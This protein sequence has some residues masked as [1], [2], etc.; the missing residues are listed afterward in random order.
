MCNDVCEFN[1][2]S[3]S[4]PIQIRVLSLGRTYSRRQSSSS[5]SSKARARLELVAVSFVLSVFRMFHTRTENH[6]SPPRVKLLIPPRSRKITENPLCK[7]RGSNPAAR[8]I[9]RSYSH[10]ASALAAHLGFFEH[11]GNFSPITLHFRIHFTLWIINP[12]LHV[13]CGVSPIRETPIFPFPRDKSYTH[14]TP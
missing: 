1:L 10:V 12:S 11:F 6:N 7:L 4:N 2:I 9:A 5:S 13:T 3:V 14:D 8:S